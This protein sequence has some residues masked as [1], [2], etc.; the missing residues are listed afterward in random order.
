MQVEPDWQ[1]VDPL[2]PIPPHWPYFAEQLV[3]PVVAGGETVVV[4]VVG[5]RLVVVVVVGGR[6]VLVVVTPPVGA[7]PPLPQTGGP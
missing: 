5:G 6:T 7:T 2:K 1:Q 3:E 4:V